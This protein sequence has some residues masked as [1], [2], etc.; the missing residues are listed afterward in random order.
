LIGVIDLE[1]AR[2]RWWRRILVGIISITI[3]NDHAET[4]TKCKEQPHTGQFNAG[5]IRVGELAQPRCSTLGSIDTCTSLA[6]AVS[7]GAIGPVNPEYVGWTTTRVGFGTWHRITDGAVAKMSIKLSIEHSIPNR[8]VGKLLETVTSELG[9]G[10]L[11]GCHTVGLEA[12][13]VQD[14]NLSQ[15]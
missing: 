4:P 10:T 14:I 2:F 6:T 15:V 7:L 11:L 1:V 9:K 8:A 13:N 12:I 3:H 5:S